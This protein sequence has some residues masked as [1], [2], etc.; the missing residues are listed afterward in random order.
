MEPDRADLKI[1][2]VGV[3]R[4]GR[5]HAENL[6][7]HPLVGRLV[8]AG[9]TPTRAAALAA[10][11]GCDW[12]A[13]DEVFAVGNPLGLDGVVIATSTSTHADLLIRAAEAGLPVFCEK[14][15][16]LELGAALAAQEALERSGVP[17]H[18]GFQRRFDAGY[19]TAKA[20]LAAGE[21]G[22]LRRFNAVTGDHVPPTPDYI[23][24]SGGIFLDASVHDMDIIAWVTGH[25]IVEVYSRGTDRGRPEFAENGDLSD[26]VTIVTLDD[27]T[28]G[29]VHVSRYNGQGHEVRLDLMGTA[30]SVNVGLDE[31]VPF[32]SAEPGVTFPAQTPWYDFIER[33]EPCYE[34]ELDHFLRNPVQGRPGACSAAEAVQALRAAL[35]CRLSSREGRAVRVAE[36]GADPR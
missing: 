10:E 1:A 28:I 36:I 25:Q 21:L 27:G 24:N 4:I 6:L 7:R 11:L 13:V 16:G 12:A 9:A 29:T 35:A 17:H 23:P 19:T 32:R 15:I 2:L 31:K 8:L 18:I 34:R 22:E 14:P 20:R 26:A 30:G 33:F 5:M 3:G